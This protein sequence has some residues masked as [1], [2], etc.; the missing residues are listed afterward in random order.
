MRSVLILLGL[1]ALASACAYSYDAA[2]RLY[3]PDTS[4]DKVSECFSD[5]D[6]ALITCVGQIPENPPDYDGA[7]WA[8]FEASGCLL[9]EVEGDDE[10]T[11]RAGFEAF[12]V[13][14]LGAEI[15]GGHPLDAVWRDTFWTELE[16]CLVG[17]DASRELTID[18]CY[19]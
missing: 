10:V 15:D 6:Q 4:C 5:R 9:T 7:L 2:G 1:L 14:C 16:A 3:P 18:V 12:L 19:E 13:G 8:C 11:T 17:A